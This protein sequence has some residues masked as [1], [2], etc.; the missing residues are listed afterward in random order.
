MSGY[1]SPDAVALL[2]AGHRT[3]E[4]L[5]AQVAQTDESGKKEALVLEISTELSIHAAIE[6]EVFYPACQ[7]RIAGLPALEDAY[8]EHDSAKVL[9]AELIDG[10]PDG[11][12]YDAKIRMLAQLVAKHVEEEERTPDGLFARARAAGL[13]LEALGDRMEGKRNV[14]SEQ[15][16]GSRLPPPQTRSFK[17]HVLVQGKPVKKDGDDIEPR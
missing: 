12:F 6:E 4:K 5:F 2:T 9:I 13:D 3:V 15:F 17:G 8:V 1:R 16:E 10:A 11:P 14:L 7:E